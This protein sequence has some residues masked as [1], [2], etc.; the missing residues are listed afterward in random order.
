M[1]EQGKPRYAFFEGRIVPIADAKISVMN[2]AFN[3]G[4]GV[5]GGL[6][7]YWNDAQEQL[8]IFR[9]NDHF[10]RF[11]QSA[12]LIRIH[13]PRTVNEL[14]EILNDL[15]RTEG[16]RENVYIRPLAYKSAEMIGV[17]LHDVPDAFTMFALVS[18]IMLLVTKE[19]P[20]APVAAADKT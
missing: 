19:K 15:L 17:R 20:I 4:T 11:I 14:I 5:F 6:R 8:Y 18:G 7:G 12:A 3:Y 13:V 1:A 10:E 9:P 2:H 16:F